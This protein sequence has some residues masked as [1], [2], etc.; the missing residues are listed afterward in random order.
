MPTLV[1]C[2][3][4]AT[5]F[6]ISDERASRPVR[7]ARCGTNFAVGQI[8]GELRSAKTPQTIDRYVIKSKLGAGAFGVVYRAHHP[9]LDRDVAL[10]VLKPMS[11]SAVARFLR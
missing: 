9:V 10:K 2:P 4:C 6:N 3:K 1:R 8:A 5:S 11:E 7:C